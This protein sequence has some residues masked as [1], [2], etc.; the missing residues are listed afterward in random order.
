VDPSSRKLASRSLAS[1]SPCSADTKHVGHAS[2]IASEVSLDEYDVVVSVSGDGTLHELINGFAKHKEPMRAFRM[3][4]APIPAGSG[5]AMSL[6]L[7]GSEVRALSSY[8][9]R[10]HSSSSVLKDGLDIA[11]AT[12]NAIKGRPMAID[13]LSVLQS[14]KR[15]F[16]FLSQC[17]G[18]MADLDL[19]TEHMRWMGSN[20]FLYG[21][22]RGGKSSV[23]PPF[24]PPSPPLR[25]NETTTNPSFSPPSSNAQVVPVRNLHQK[26]H[27][28]QGRDGRS[29]ATV[30]HVRTS[31]RCPT[32]RGRGRERD[33]APPSA[34]RRRT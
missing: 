1:C 15:S 2:E 29:P 16:S 8:P 33:G 11:A 19:G 31:L 13:L 3:P 32:G 27:F 10:V 7:L 25:A 20:R 24:P 9:T 30:Q 12:L 14:G 17:V 18:L 5:N 26:R 22:L 28:G 23:F 21:F 6:N 34:I 4:I